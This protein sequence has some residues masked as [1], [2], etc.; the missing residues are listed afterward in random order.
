[1]FKAIL[2]LMLLQLSL[3]AQEASETKLHKLYGVHFQRF[4]RDNPVALIALHDD[5]PAS[6]RLI[7]RLGKLAERL[8]EEDVS[9]KIATMSVKEAPSYA[10]LWKAYRLPHARFYIGDGVYDD[11]RGHPSSAA[12]YKWIKT[13]LTNPSDIRLIDSE[14]AAHRFNEEPFAFYL[15]FP[16]SQPQFLELLK[17]FSKLDGKLKVFYT[18]KAVFD[19]FESYNPQEIVVGMRRP[20]DD[21]SKVLSSKRL[22]KATVQ[23][24]FEH[25]RHPETFKLTPEVARVLEAPRQ[26]TFVLFDKGGRS[27]LFLEFKNLA[28]EFK[29]AFQF[30]HAD[31]KEEAAGQLAA[32]ARVAEKNL[33]ALRIIDTVAGAQ[34][35]FE[36]PLGSFE[37]IVANIEKYEKGQLPNLLDDVA[38]EL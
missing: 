31:L 26:R 23:N 1:M 2:T 20:F 36:V 5:S 8:A 21:G 16:E 28:A 6:Q 33:P 29:L 12:L 18:H 10:K 14:P 30:V 38:S 4:L 24:F 11:F 27:E 7:T 15:R 37:D 13:I 19:A 34:R 35:V 25:F 17:K 32:V 9:V 22:T 3:R